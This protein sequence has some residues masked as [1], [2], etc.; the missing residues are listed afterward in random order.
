MT[1]SQFPKEKGS[2]YPTSGGYGQSQGSESEGSIGG[3]FERG[4]SAIAEHT[5]RTTE[6]L[7]REVAE[8]RAELVK[9]QQ[10][11]SR[12][13]ADTGNEAMR[14]AKDVGKAVANTAS[15]L[16]EAGSDMAASAT[17]QAKTFASELES[18][19]RNNPMPTLAG[20]LVVGMLIGFCTRGRG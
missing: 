16:V 19:A 1:A 9:M 20:T 5:T 15:D 17:Q 11:V 18:M 10:T 6:E 14:T 7:T 13:A 3:A 8:L 2:S 12:Y 4:S